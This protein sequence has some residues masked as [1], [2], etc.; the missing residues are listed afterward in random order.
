MGDERQTGSTGERLLT[1]L[2]A[3]VRAETPASLRALTEAVGLP[4]P[5][6]HRLIKLLE[7][8]GYATKDLTGR[9]YVPGPMLRDLAL[10]VIQN[11]TAS[12]ARHLIL[13]RLA[14]RVG[15]ACNI[16]L[17][18]GGKLTYIDRVDTAWPLRV[19]LEIGSHVPLHCTATGKLLLA[20]Q[21]KRVRDRLIQA[22][23]L[24]VHTPRTITDPAALEAAIKVIRRERT[25]T[26]DQEFLP[27]MVAIAV[28]ID[29]QRAP[30]IA[31]ISIH[32]PVF[33]RT[34]D[35]LRTF[36]PQLREAAQALSDLL[37]G[38]DDTQAPPRQ[39]AEI[40]NNAIKQP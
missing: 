4:K 8:T 7:R 28:P 23:P 24:H 3:L 19:R 9:H 21:P 16:V 26:D 32:A 30:P 18:D 39:R 12:G 20:L 35:D 25:G 22:A 6:V 40:I 31:A 17:L 34:L 1:I 36:L 2:N 37:Y 13:Q 38:G 29:A 15:E 10:G 5:T 33:R 14:N 27:E 11:Q